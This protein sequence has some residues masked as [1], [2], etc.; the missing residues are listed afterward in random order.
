MAR[1]AQPIE[2][3]KAAWPG[4]AAALDSLLDSLA[5]RVEQLA[6][7]HGGADLEIHFRVHGGVLSEARFDPD[8][9][10]A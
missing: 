8:E 1:V 10:F 7:S 9:R 6:V 4:K 2:R 5:D 3:I